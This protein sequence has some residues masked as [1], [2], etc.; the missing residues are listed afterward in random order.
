MHYKPHTRSTESSSECNSLFHSSQIFCYSKQKSVKDLHVGQETKNIEIH[1]DHR[2]FVR[3]FTTR[4]TKIKRKSPDKQEQWRGMEKEIIG[5]VNAETPV[6]SDPTSWLV[7]AF[8]S[9]PLIALLSLKIWARMIRFQ[10]KKSTACAYWVQTTVCRSDCW[11][12]GAPAF[13]SLL[14]SDS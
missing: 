11:R 3:P 10:P 8:T 4:R 1:R 9:S 14:S 6:M 12:A 13:S 7:L 5:Y 2:S